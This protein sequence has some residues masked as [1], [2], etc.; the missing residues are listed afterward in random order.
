MN[1]RYETGTMNDETGA[2]R[3]HVFP[4]R[5]RGNST[6]RN[7]DIGCHPRKH[8]EMKELFFF[9]S[10]LSAS[11]REPLPGYTNKAL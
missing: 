11:L 5:R 9:F 10:A 2:M 7:Q 3:R 8:D 1:R 6:M 4:S